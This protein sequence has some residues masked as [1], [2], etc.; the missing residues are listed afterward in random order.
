MKKIL[1]SACV[2]NNFFFFLGW[3]LESQSK[4]IDCQHCA[5]MLMRKVSERRSLFFFFF[6]R[7]LLVVV[8]L[9]ETKWAEE[10]CL[11]AAS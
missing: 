11:L 9:N 1:I 5:H 7:L 4:E 2:C 10:E 8:A 3:L 6:F